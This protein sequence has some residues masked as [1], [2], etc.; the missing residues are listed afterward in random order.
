MS[1]Q[2]RID[3]LDSQRLPQRRWYHHVSYAL[4]QGS[5]AVAWRFSTANESVHIAL[6]LWKPL[7]G[8]VKFV[9][10]QLSTRKESMRKMEVSK[11]KVRNHIIF[12]YS[13]ITVCGRP[14]KIS[15]GA[16]LFEPSAR[17]AVVV[18]SG[19]PPNMYPSVLPALDLNS[20]ISVSSAG[21]G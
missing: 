7:S 18:V 10:F 6:G 9:S 15:S 11:F 19:T 12:S 5:A 13:N 4:K 8:Y 17:S 14:E 20:I 1:N 16:R 2:M 21:F 3:Y